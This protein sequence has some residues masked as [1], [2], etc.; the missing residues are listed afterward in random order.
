VLFRKSHYLIKY[1]TYPINKDV[2]QQ[3][4]TIPINIEGVPLE[5]PVIYTPPVGIY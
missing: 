3:K 5:E 4:D 1:V 2:S